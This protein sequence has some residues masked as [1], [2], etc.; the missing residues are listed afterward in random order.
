LTGQRRPFFFGTG[1]NIGLRVGF[2]GDAPSSVRFG[3]NREELSI[4]PMQRADPL[5]GQPD[6]YAS[7]LAAINMND[8]IASPQGTSVKPTQF[9]ATGAAAR[10]LAKREEIRGYFGEQ[11][12]AAVAASFTGEYAFDE[13]GKK[14]RAFWKPDG[15]TVNKD[16]DAKLKACLKKYNLNF[17]VVYLMDAAPKAEKDLIISCFQT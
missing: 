2:A 8:T 9:F 5:S 17:S 1:T 14:I 7:V 11:A 6:K 16:R 13:S 3:F 12:K 15:T 10:N 4:I